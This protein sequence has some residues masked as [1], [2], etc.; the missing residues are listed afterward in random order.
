MKRR[1]R[2]KHLEGSGQSSFEPPS[3]QTGAV[4]LVAICRSPINYYVFY[5]YCPENN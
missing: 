1:S 5:L 2:R 4:G 3:E